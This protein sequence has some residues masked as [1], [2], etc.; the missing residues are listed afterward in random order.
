[1]VDLKNVWLKVINQPFSFSLNNLIFKQSILI[2][3]PALLQKCFSSDNQVTR[4]DGTPMN[5]MDVKPGDFI[6]AVDSSGRLIDSEVVQ[7][8][9]KNLNSSS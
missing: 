1:M 3:D 9:H 7:I 4:S 8:L 6:K 5:I 2:T